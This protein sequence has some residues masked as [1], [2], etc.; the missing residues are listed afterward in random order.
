MLG[1]GG[2]SKWLPDPPQPTLFYDF[3]SKIDTKSPECQDT[4]TGNEQRKSG[5][6]QAHLCIK[7]TPPHTKTYCEQ[8]IQRT[9]VIY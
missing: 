5:Y 9:W 1:T 4:E 7:K 3:N 2:W 8:F 6:T